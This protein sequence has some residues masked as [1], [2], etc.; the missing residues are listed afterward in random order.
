MSALDAKVRATAWVS[1]QSVV[2][3]GIEHGLPA[4][5]SLELDDIGIRV[6]ITGANAADAWLDTIVVTDTRT[7]P[8]PGCIVGGERERVYVTG[9]LPGLLGQ[10]KVELRFSRPAMRLQAVT[11]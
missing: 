10:V 9:H 6:W 4:P 11:A 5:E 2:A 3:H 8:V 7:R 1:Y